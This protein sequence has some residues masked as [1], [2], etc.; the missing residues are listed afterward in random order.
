ML[1]I[2]TANLLLS[3]HCWPPKTGH[4]DDRRDRACGHV[5]VKL[6]VT[7]AST[8]NSTKSAGHSPSRSTVPVSCLPGIMVTPQSRV[9]SAAYWQ[10]V[11][12][13]VSGRG[14][15]MRLYDK[16]RLDAGDPH[17]SGASASARPTWQ[18]AKE[19]Y[20]NFRRGRFAWLPL[21]TC[22]VCS[23]LLL[24]Y[25][26]LHTCSITY[27]SMVLSLRSRVSCPETTRTWQCF[28]R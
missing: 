11:V 4:D 3:K 14:E 6:A 18:A 17:A 25:G 23:A 15:D 21:S 10:F 1:V 2:R 13:S 16:M 27:G 24:R 5:D 12:M 20:L 28:L 22:T 19:A 9:R 7:R 8:A 26:S